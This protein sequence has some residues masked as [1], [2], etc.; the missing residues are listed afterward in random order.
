MKLFWATKTFLELHSKTA[1][2]YSPK[3]LKQMVENTTEQKHSAAPYRRS[4]VIQISGKY[5]DLKSNWKDVTY[6]N[7]K[8]EIFTVAAELKVLT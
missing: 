3:Q 5:R 7:F 6:T 4:G 1:S 2:Q 8:A